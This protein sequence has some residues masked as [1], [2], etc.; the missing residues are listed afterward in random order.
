LIF[1][2]QVFAEERIRVEVNG[3]EVQFTDTE[4]VIINGRTMV[5]LRGVF[6]QTGFTVDWDT[7]TSAALLYR[8]GISISVT[9]G[10]TF[11]TVN[12]ER[13][14]PDVPP[15]IINSRFMLPLRTVSEA[16]GD[17]VDWDE[18]TSTAK[19]TT[20]TVSESVRNELT[21]W[22][23]ATASIINFENHENPRLFDLPA[24]DALAEISASILRNSWNANDKNG[25]LRAIRSLYSGHNANFMQMHDVFIRAVNEFGMDLFLEVFIEEER[26]AAEAMGIEDVAAFPLHTLELGEKWGERGILAWDMFRIGTLVSWGYAAGYINRNEAL[27]LIEPAA[28]VLK[29]NFSSWEEAAENYID[30]FNWWSRGLNP[31]TAESRLHSFKYVIPDMVSGIYDDTLFAEPPIVNLQRTVFPT[32]ESIVGEFVIGGDSVTT[33]YNF[34]ADGTFSLSVNNMLEFSGNYSFLGKGKTQ[35]DYQYLDTGDGPM[36]FSS[37]EIHHFFLS[38]DGNYLIDIETTGW[39]SS[40]FSR[41]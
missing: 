4:P 13:I 8:E 29:I 26:E 41:V 7:E 25:L 1:A 28:N 33:A 19:I 3:H 22:I 37:S 12:N 16:T 20:V 38:A 6:E 40:F 35:L 2:A 9:I 21:A 30:G 36:P 32:Q 31:E 39:E 18:E 17:Y 34:N 23:T 5:P 11:I 14:Y 15:Q 10:D 24:D 27:M